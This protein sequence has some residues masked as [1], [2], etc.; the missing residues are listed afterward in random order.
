MSLWPRSARTAPAA[1]SGASNWPRSIAYAAQ[2]IACPDGLDVIAR[3][4]QRAMARIDVLTAQMTAVA[5]EIDALLANLEE[6]PLPGDDSRPGLGQP[7][8]ALPPIRVLIAGAHH[9]GVFS[10][11]WLG[12]GAPF[13]V[14]GLVTP[15]L[16]QPLPFR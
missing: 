11:C 7:G 1:G 15:V 8:A 9:R 12:H 16:R 13:P 10:A 5:T 6:A 2:T 14:P 3:E 4:V